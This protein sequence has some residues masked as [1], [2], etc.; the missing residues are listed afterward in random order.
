MAWV[1]E[2]RDRDCRHA[3][4]ITPRGGSAAPRAARLPAV[5]RRLLRAF[6]WLTY[7]GVLLVVFAAVGYLS[8]SKFVRSGGTEVP[9]LVGL[10]SDQLPGVVAEYG[11]EL[12]HREGSE[13][14]DDVVPP[15]HV[16]RQS[17]PAGSM[18]KR[19]S[20]VDII[21]SLGPQLTQVPD[22]RGE[23]LQAAQVTL[24]AAGLAVG[25]TAGVHT[26]E[27]EPGTVFEQFPPAGERVG[28]ASSVDLFL[29]VSSR[30]ST[31]LMPDLVYRDY[32]SVRSFFE[33]RG[34]RLGSV[35]FEPYE[36]VA[37]GIVLRQ[38]PLPGHPLRR[39]DAISLV[40]VSPATAVSGS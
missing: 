37:A 11:L 36:S 8:F 10:S 27:A 3:V 23:A 4:S 15:G 20:T 17:P 35:K 9:E 39:Q 34:F 25:R 38:F 30:T 28:G 26:F 19:G 33:A 13:R 22:V 5:L 14:Y 40:V 31:F 21:L 32:E 24:A 6:G 2:G 18:V 1:P 16:L 7:A 29:A 12:R